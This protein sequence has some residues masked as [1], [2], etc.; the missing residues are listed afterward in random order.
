MLF[1]EKYDDAEEGEMLLSQ[2]VSRTSSSTSQL[3]TIS[4]ISSINSLKRPAIEEVVDPDST[5]ILTTLPLAPSNKLASLAL[6]TVIAGS[7]NRKRDLQGIQMGKPPP[8]TSISAFVPSMFSPGFKE[9]MAHN[10][11]FLPTISDAICSSWVRNV[12]GVV[13]RQKLVA[14]SNAKV[15]EYHDGDG[16]DGSAERLVSVVQARL[17]RMLQR[18]LYDEDAAKKLWKKNK[19]QG[20]EN[21]NME[22]KESGDE[23]LLGENRGE[24]TIN[25]KADRFADCIR[26]DF[27]DDNEELLFEDLLAGGI[28]RESDDGLLDYFEDQERLAIEAETEGMLFGSGRDRRLC[29]AADDEDELLLL[30]DGR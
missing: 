20:A 29:N 23:D 24:K 4:S 19:G 1:D 30:G 7:S 13:L 12:Q 25:T 11:K 18:T 2:T 5:P 27:M 22:A 21:P 14:L 6:Q 8:S 9:L 10:S 26:E 28:D 15:S 16:E 17:W 3:S